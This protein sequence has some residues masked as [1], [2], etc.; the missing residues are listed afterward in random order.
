MGP[1]QFVPPWPIHLP[2]L[3]LCAASLLALPPRDK[4]PRSQAESE[5]DQ[6]SIPIFPTLVTYLA[7]FPHLSI[8]WAV[9]DFY[10]WQGRRT[11]LALQLLRSKHL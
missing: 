7:R 4:T 11:Q 2:L 3:T 9:D 5:T 8:A 1:S 6:R 10:R